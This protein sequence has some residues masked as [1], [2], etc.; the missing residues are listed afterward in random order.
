MSVV[1]NQTA[2]E[3][4]TVVVTA[5]TTKALATK[6]IHVPEVRTKA[7]G[8]GTTAERATKSKALT[9]APFLDTEVTHGANAGPTDSMK[10]AVSKANG[11]GKETTRTTV[12]TPAHR[13][14]RI[15]ATTTTY[16]I[17]T[18]QQD[19]MQ[20]SPIS[21]R[22]K[23]KPTWRKATAL[24]QRPQHDSST[25]LTH[26][27]PTK[28]M[29]KKNDLVLSRLYAWDYINRWSR[30]VMC[31]PWRPYSKHSGYCKASQWGDRTICFSL[32]TW[33]Q[34][35]ACYTPAA[36]SVQRIRNIS[37]AKAW[38]L[39]PQLVH[40]SSM[41]LPEFSF[42]RKVKG[43]K[44]IFL[45]RRKSNMTLSSGAVL[46]IRRKSTYCR[47]N[48]NACGLTMRFL[49]TRH[50]TFPTTKQSEMYSKWNLCALTDKKPTMSLRQSQHLQI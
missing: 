31:L 24:Q 25:D 18:C 12:A 15:K 34:R 5:T 10:K 8:T 30:D 46:W 11:K 26:S 41:S 4:T 22:N 50:I 13:P 49:F 14:V 44:S 33:P 7:T 17:T 19:W 9:H 16:K 40:L 3:E 39:K 23:V 38:V 36:L 47:L 43:E 42:T 35:L 21:I 20:G 1:S 48:S 45:T 2:T 27:S 37:K 29:W 6:T 32:V 28:T